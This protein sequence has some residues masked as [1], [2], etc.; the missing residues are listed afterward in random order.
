VVLRVVLYCLFV[1]VVVGAVFLA[2]AG[3]RRKDLVG[4]DADTAR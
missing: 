4:E 2:I 1:S 3:R